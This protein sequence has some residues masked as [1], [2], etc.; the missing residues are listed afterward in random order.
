MGCC[1]HENEPLAVVKKALSFLPL[2]EWLLASR[3]GFERQSV[4]VLDSMEWWSW[5]VKRQGDGLLWT[6]KWTFGCGKKS[7]E[8][9]AP[10]GMTA[11]IPKRFWKT[12]RVCSWLDG[13]MIMNGEQARIWEEKVQF[14]VL[15]R[16]SLRGTDES[17]LPDISV[18]I[19]TGQLR[20][21]VTLPGPL[22]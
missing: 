5:M 14:K 7:L 20:K 2:R 6:R 22:V 15:P 13:M 10:T 8:F 11:S 18:G 19:R 4:Y 9:L 21:C 17:Y 1:E 16:H 3:K 12:E